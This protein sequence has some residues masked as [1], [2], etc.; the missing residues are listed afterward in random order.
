MG[1]RAPQ[2]THARRS[3]QPSRTS[4]CKDRRHCLLKVDD[5]DP[6]GVCRH[7]SGDSDL[8]VAD[9]SIENSPVL[10]LISRI[11]NPRTNRRRRISAHC[12]TPTTL[13]LPGSL[14]A[15]KPRVRRPP[16]SCSGGPDFNR[17]RRSSFNPAPT[18]KGTSRER[19]CR[20][21][22]R[23]TATR[24]HSVQRSHV[25]RHLRPCICACFNRMST[26]LKSW[27]PRSSPGLAIDE[28]PANSGVQP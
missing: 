15:D 5:A 26:R 11:D 25:R 2:D 8:R 3:H 28:T 23:R 9:L 17:H 18:R 24:H 14:C 13:A 1:I 21:L 6:S 19:S 16:D 12:S 4:S 20:Y 27:C 10:R 22:R 7:V